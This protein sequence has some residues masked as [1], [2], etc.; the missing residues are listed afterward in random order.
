ML[1]NWFPFVRFHSFDVVLAGSGPVFVINGLVSVIEEIRFWSPNGFCWFGTVF[2]DV[3]AV[4]V[5]LAASLFVV[6]GLRLSVCFVLMRPHS[7]S[8]GFLS[9]TI[10]F[11]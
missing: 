7:A 10:G 6:C 5:W 8:M 3:Q 2:F 11:R 1:H 4:Q 9:C